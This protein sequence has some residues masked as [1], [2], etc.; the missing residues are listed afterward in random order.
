MVSDFE[1]M[2]WL[3]DFL[4]SGLLE[5]CLTI[6]GIIVAIGMLL[7]LYRLW[8]VLGTIQQTLKGVS[9]YSSMI[10][11]LMIE[12]RKFCIRFNAPDSDEE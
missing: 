6:L 8:V 3:W 12:F 4:D 1:V 9:F 10:K 11:D 7:V 2:K 5:V